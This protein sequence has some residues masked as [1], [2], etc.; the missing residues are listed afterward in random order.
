MDNDNTLPMVPISQDRLSYLLA[1]LL[2]YRQHCTR[3]MSPSERRNTTLLVLAF[4]LPKLERGTHPAEGEASPL[5]LTTAEVRVIQAGLATILDQLNH[6]PASP[7]IKQEMAR[8]KDLKRLF[9]QHFG[10]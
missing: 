2:V 10:H 1:A 6:K 5:W 4:L 8:L 7:S 9:E 3:K